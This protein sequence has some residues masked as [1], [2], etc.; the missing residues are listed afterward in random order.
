MKKFNNTALDYGYLG[1][2]I[3]SPIIDPIKLLSSIP[4]Y[5]RYLH[6]LVKYKTMQGSES[7]HPL[8]L[9]PVLQEWTPTT[10]FDTHYFYQDSWAFRRIYQ[11]KTRSH[12]DVGSTITF[13]S[14]LAAVTKVTF[15]DIRP[16][17]ATLKNLTCIKGDI[18]SMPFPDNSINS[19]SCLHVAEHIGLGRY[20]D[21][22]DPDGTKKACKELARVLAPGGTLYFSLPI[23]KPRL[24]YNAHRVHSPNQILKYFH[25][26]KLVEL[27][28]VDDLG[29]FKEH[30][31]KKILD[32]ADYGC[33]LF[34][35]T[36]K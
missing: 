35:F 26:L 4:G 36:K 20:G 6:D 24:C 12:V 19:L 29:N 17:E 34:I 23:G 31:D 1:Y 7:L 33:G 13:V 30:I 21:P 2:R 8:N 3:V 14:F 25:G 28:G 10:P 5:A 11:S 18:L 27:S 16:L 9:Y 22:L 32:H 15:M